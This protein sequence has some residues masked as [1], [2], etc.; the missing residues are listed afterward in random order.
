MGCRR[1]MNV[2]TVIVA[3]IHTSC[4]ATLTSGTILKITVNSSVITTS[5]QQELRISAA[6][7]RPGNSPHVETSHQRPMPDGASR[8]ANSTTWECSLRQAQRD[9]AIQVMGPREL[10]RCF[11]AW[12][13]RSF[14]ATMGAESLARDSA[15]PIRRASR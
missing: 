1:T 9:G 4:Q 6:A 5:D 3:P 12:L 11:S 7:C 13:G 2:A 14:I 8:N 10:V 15:Q